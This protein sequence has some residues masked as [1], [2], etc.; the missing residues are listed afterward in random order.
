MFYVGPGGQEGRSGIK[1]H[2]RTSRMGT[3]WVRMLLDSFC[4]STM[5]FNSNSILKLG[6]CTVGQVYSR[7]QIM[8][9]ISGSFGTMSPSAISSL[10]TSDA[11]HFHS[12]F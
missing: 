1:L 8:N 11:T 12:K 7:G 6:E 2:E 10:W 4:S 5:T 9:I 3:L